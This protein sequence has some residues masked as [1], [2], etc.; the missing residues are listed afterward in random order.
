MQI[1]SKQFLPEPHPLLRSPSQGG[2]HEE[3]LIKIFNLTISD[4]FNTW[5][6]IIALSKTC[7]T[8]YQL[9]NE[10]K[11]IIPL[12]V[13]IHSDQNFAALKKHIT[14]LG[15][16]NIA[17]EFTH[18]LEGSL[19]LNANIRWAANAPSITTIRIPNIHHSRHAVE[20]DLLSNRNSCLKLCRGNGLVLSKVSQGL[21]GDREIVLAAVKQNGWALEYANDELKG[22]REIVLAA[23]KQYGLALMLANEERKGD[24]EIVL[25]AVK[26]N[27]LALQFANPK[28]QGDRVIV[29][30]AV[31]QDGWALRFA[32]EKFQGDREIVLAA[33]KQDGSALQFA[34]KEFQGDREIV[35]AAAEQ[36]R[37]ALQ[38]AIEELQ[39]DR[40]I[41]Q[42]PPAV[43]LLKPKRTSMVK[44]YLRS[45]TNTILSILNFIM[46]C[47]TSR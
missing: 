3:L 1:V 42:H 37:G 24:R 15:I 45:F 7:K 40:E 18:H 23:V 47:F 4:K 32:N 44:N 29:L 38:R 28:L 27:G 26:Q 30:A 2:I 16:T 9:G 13:R 17:I 19:C 39:D 8:G 6:S 20:D 11:K 10:L 31:Q 43:L 35:L 21:R 22:G 41:Y 12:G 25:A 5:T 33:V 46:S 34:K 36:N 14:Q